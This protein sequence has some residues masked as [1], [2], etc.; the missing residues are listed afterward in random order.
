MPKTCSHPGC[1]WPQWGGGFCKL[2]QW[3]RKDKKPRPIPRKSGEI[4]K[5][6]KQQSVNDRTFFMKIWRD[7]PHI[8]AYCGDTLIGGPHNYNFDH[9]LEKSSFPS[10]RYETDNIRLTCLECHGV[11][12]SQ[13]YTEIM[14]EIIKKVAGIFVLRKMLHQIGPIDVYRQ[15]DWIIE[16]KDHHHVIKGC[17]NNEF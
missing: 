13:R 8:C 12:T 14:A 11:K 16:N 3:C 15:K 9:V 4:I 2:H 17:E 7:R 10:L 1:A 5:K 6:E